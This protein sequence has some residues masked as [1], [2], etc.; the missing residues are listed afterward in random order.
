METV[1]GLD[2]RLALDEQVEVVVVVPS[3]VGHPSWQDQHQKH[4][5]IQDPAHF[6]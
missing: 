3:A 4:S 5:L 2:G 6:L 1:R